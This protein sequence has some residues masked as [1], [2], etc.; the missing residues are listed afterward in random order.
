MSGASLTRASIGATVLA[1]C[2]LVC[3]C[4]SG[5][6]P[7]GYHGGGGLP[8]GTLGM[9]C[10]LT[11]TGPT[12]QAIYNCP[13]PEGQNFVPCTAEGTAPV[14]GGGAGRD[15]S[16]PGGGFFGLEFTD[17]GPTKT[18][19]EM[20]TLLG[21]TAFSYSVSCGNQGGLQESDQQ[22]QPVCPG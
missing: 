6:C 8:E 16:L 1:L 10:T 7:L 2:V 3:A 19:T 18:A 15:L 13:P 20:V 11:I 21:S 14:L 4:G 17:V 5:P 12:G 9:T 22:I